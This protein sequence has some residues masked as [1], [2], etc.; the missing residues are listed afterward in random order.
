MHSSGA[1]SASFFRGLNSCVNYQTFKMSKR[2]KVGVCSR[3]VATR[4]VMY[5]QQSSG[6]NGHDRYLLI[7]YSIVFTSNA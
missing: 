4:D 3:N 1:T 2:L 5:F 6:D 7:Q